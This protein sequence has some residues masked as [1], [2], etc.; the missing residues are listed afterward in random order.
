M[1]DILRILRYIRRVLDSDEEGTLE[2]ELTFEYDWITPLSFSI[3]VIDK[4]SLY[5]VVFFV[6]I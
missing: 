2:K 5:K 3:V 1:A 4:V 6:E